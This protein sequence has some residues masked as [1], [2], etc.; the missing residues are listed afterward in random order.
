[1]RIIPS[2]DEVNRSTL[3]VEF[4][5]IVRASQ[6]GVGSERL[7]RHALGELFDKLSSDLSIALDLLSLGVGSTDAPTVSKLIYVHAVNLI[8]SLIVSVLSKAVTSGLSSQNGFKVRFFDG[9]LSSGSHDDYRENLLSKRESSRDAVSALNLKGFRD[10]EYLLTAIFGGRL[11]ELNFAL[12]DQFFTRRD[13]LLSHDGLDVEGQSVQLAA[14][15]VEL[16]IVAIRDFA[17]D[18]N[19]KIYHLLF[20]HDSSAT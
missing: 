2:S 4:S 1:M 3:D 12:I 17:V 19:I 9:G 8:E 6:G 11:E 7:T 16:V 20:H 10:F 15:E 18:L 13:W 5:A 14:E